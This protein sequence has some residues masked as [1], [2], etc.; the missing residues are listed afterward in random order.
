MTTVWNTQ[1][2]TA[3]VIRSAGS[4][5][6]VNVKDGQYGAIGDGVTDDGNALGAALDAAESAGGGTVFVPYGTYA[7]ATSPNFARVG[8]SVEAEHGAVFLHTGTGNAFTIDGGAEPTG[9]IF[10][11]RFSNIIV[12]GNANS[13]HGMY[14]RAIHHS[15][16]DHPRVTGCAITGAAYQIEWCVANQWNTPVVSENQGAFSSVPLYGMYLTRRG[17]SESTTTQT[18]LNPVMEGVGTGIVFDWANNNSVM[19]GTSEQNAT[20]VYITINSAGNVIELLDMEVNTTE[21]VLC[22]GADHIFI[23]ILST[24][25]VR[26]SGLGGSRCK[27]IGGRYNAIT[28]EADT[29]NNSL[30]GLTYSIDGGSL[31]DLGTNNSVFRVQNLT[32]TLFDDAGTWTPSVGGTATYTTQLGRYTKVGNQVTV[33]FDVQ[34]N[35]IGTGSTTTIS[36]L[37]F[38]SNSFA[39]GT[40]FWLNGAAL[41]V[42]MVS[43]TGVGLTTITLYGTTSASASLFPTAIF[44]SGARVGGTLVYTV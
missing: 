20:G 19:N 16:F 38:A 14:V 39:T 15:V 3:G 26:F 33:Y 31:T 36:G 40:V 32:T 10:G 7:Y 9:G 12:Q 5:M 23:G 29:L 28:L 17:A 11:L 4:S 8:V 1:P 44:A 18:I 6:F 25:L 27:L 24:N 2:S 22:E 35:S 43:V 41:P 34:I 42:Y 37:P 21:D 13:T 30:I